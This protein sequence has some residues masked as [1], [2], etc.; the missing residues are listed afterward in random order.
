VGR[1]N[2][3]AVKEGERCNE[4]TLFHLLTSVEVVLRNKLSF[5]L[6]PWHI[7]TLPTHEDIRDNFI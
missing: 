2:H 5:F 7:L 4:K 6:M 3:G 1:R